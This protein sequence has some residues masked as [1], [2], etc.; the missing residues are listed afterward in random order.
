MILY[1]R[2]NYSLSAGS[3]LTLLNPFNF[4]NRSE[5]DLSRFFPGKKVFFY[6]HARSGLTQIL[7]LFQ[8]GSVVGVQPFTCPTVLKAIKNAGCEICFVDIN[9]SLIID[10]ET[11]KLCLAKIDILVLTHTFGYVANVQKIKEMMNGKPLIEDCAHAFLSQSRNVYAGMTGDFALFSF[12]FAKFPSAVAG[13]F[14]VVNNADYLNAFEKKY[15]LTAVPDWVDG[16]KLR[17]MAIIQL[18]LYSTPFYGLFT[19]KQI[20]RRNQTYFQNFVAEKIKLAY[21]FCLEIFQT[22]LRNIDHYL[23]VQKKN[24]DCIIQSINKNKDISFLQQSEDMN[25]FLL[26]V[27][28]EKP[29]KLIQYAQRKGIELG[30]HFYKSKYFVNH[31]GYKKGSCPQYET[32]IEKIVTIPCHYHYSRRKIQQICELINNYNNE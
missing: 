25:Y 21:P 1:P 7:S 10:E 9:S 27:H 32:L 2:L 4:A 15:E 17:M 22:E 31:F 26:V 19:S 24:A 29:E 12:G 16:V 11:I 8:K 13:G 30:R 18:I 20:A 6:N 28:T 3:C 5:P 14:V 23:Q